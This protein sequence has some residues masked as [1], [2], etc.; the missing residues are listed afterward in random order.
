MLKMRIL[1]ER[2]SCPPWYYGYVRQL[3]DWDGYEFALVPFHL[4][5]RAVHLLGLAWYA[6]RW[7]GFREDM[8]MRDARW[9]TAYEDGKKD[10]YHHGWGDCHAKYHELLKMR[11]P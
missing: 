9:K 1:V 7:Y 11:T 8:I 5:F 6:F 4:V 10:G 2:F 3:I